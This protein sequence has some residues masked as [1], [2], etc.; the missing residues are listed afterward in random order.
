MMKIL[1]VEMVVHHLVNKKLFMIVQENQVFVYI[2][3]LMDLLMQEKNAM[4]Q[5]FKMEMVVQVHF[6][7]L[8][9]K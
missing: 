7:V 5:I 3:V 9:V 8:L 2:L 4:M 1:Q 6:P